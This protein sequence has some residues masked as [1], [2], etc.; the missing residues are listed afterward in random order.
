MKEKYKEIKELVDHDENKISF[1]I[2]FLR[3]FQKLL[4]LYI[5]RRYLCQ[6][7]K[8]LTKRK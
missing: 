6:F 3:H 7:M 8:K 1:M 2:N 4:T 5:G